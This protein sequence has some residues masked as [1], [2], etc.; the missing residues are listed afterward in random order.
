MNEVTNRYIEFYN[1]LRKKEEVKGAKDFALSID[2]SISMI[3]EIVK[4]RS[5]VGV[6]AI[7][8][9]VIH[10]RLNPFWLFTGEGS[11]LQQNEKQA[12]DYAAETQ[13]NY[14]NNKQYQQIIEILREQLIVKDNE[15]KRLMSLLEDK[16]ERPTG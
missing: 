15:I 16:K 13:P 10:H 14:Q 11:M 12:I 2:V 3:T 1:F 7:Q 9:T 5:N 6:K 8:N 4:G